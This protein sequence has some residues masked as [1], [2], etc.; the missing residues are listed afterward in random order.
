MDLSF[1]FRPKLISAMKGYSKER[2]ISD[3]MA[4]IIVGIVALPLAIAFGIASGVSPEMGIITAIIGGF[5]VAALGGCSV[6]IGGPTGS[7]IVI[8]Y[9]IVQT[10]GLEGLVVATVISGVLLILMGLLKLGSVIKFI[11]YPIVV[12]YTSGTAMIIF[13]T[14]IKDFFGLTIQESGADFLSKWTSYIQAWDTINVGA[15]IVSIATM[16]LII[17]T[18]K[19]MRKIPGSLVAI[20]GVTAVTYLLR[21][22]FGIETIETIGDRF[23]LRSSLPEPTMLEL[24][25][26]TINL[27]LPSAV[28]L[29]L[30]GAIE[31][32]LSATISDGVTGEQHDSNTEL[33]AQGAANI[34]VP[35]FGGLPVTGAVARTMTNIKNGGITPISGIIHS[36]TLLLILL[37][38]GPLTQHI[39]MACLAGVLISVAYNMSEWRT[40][41][42]LLK[43]AGSDVAVLVT[44][45]SLTVLFDLT[46]AIIIGLLMAIVLFLR[47]ISEVTEVTVARS[48][49]DLS[50]DGEV[51]HDEE[52]LDI[53][54]G[55]E[56]Y[57][58]D[59]PFFFGVASKFDSVMQRIGDPAK[60]RIIRMKRV[61]FMDS[62][63]VH[64]LEALVASSQSVGIKVILSGVKPSV[65][66]MLTKANFEALIGEDAICDDI[67]EALTKANAY[68]AD[69]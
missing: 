48:K 55:V 49:L 1:K 21:Q 25:M 40:F 42:H 15:F 12:G 63:G 8:V 20:V 5:M 35:I 13:T 28:T 14:Q 69:L 19:V 11:P 44:T 9:G 29:A 45:F 6:Q 60:V 4:G 27:L 38:L 34:V 16:A 10:F 18:P 24:D 36:A 65:R 46:V 43:G 23:T 39:P 67:Q 68:V 32:L 33:M 7:F 61:P 53:R 26:D 52:V 22:Y 66:E 62:T 59:G 64:N 3:S 57:H 31:S 17:L 47:R 41:K 30:L 50:H 2:F 37:F 56:V 51:A 58:I 54:E